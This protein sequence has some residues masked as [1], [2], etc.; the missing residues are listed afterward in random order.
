[1]ESKTLCWVGRR[2][3]SGKGKEK[4]RKRRNRSSVSLRRKVN[5]TNNKGETSNTNKGVGGSLPEIVW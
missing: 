1:M 2:T 5:G 3:K 4:R